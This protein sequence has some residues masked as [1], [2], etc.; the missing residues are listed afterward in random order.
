M[1]VSIVQTDIAWANPEANATAIGRML[2]THAG[3]DLY[4]LPEMF[5][6]GFATNPDDIAESDGLSIRW[7]SEQA[8]SRQCAMMGS[9]ATKEA[10]RFFNRLYFVWPDGNME[11]YDKRH[12]F[13]HGGEDKRFT[14]GRRR[15]VVAYRGFRILLQVCYDLRF[16]VFS[17]NRQDYDMA[18]YVA[19]WPTSRLSAWTALLRARAIENQC[20]VVGVNR[21]GQDPT[22]QYSGGSEIIDFQGRTIAGCQHGMPD[23]ATAHVSLDELAEA[24]RRFAVLPDADNFTL[25]D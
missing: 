4:V 13:S 15:V 3:A 20:F 2:D 18:V 19:N 9:V 17:R 16:P 22:C 10:G 7:M 24:R 11:H 12:L 8:R 23:V 6:T 25:A 1:K 14:A 5:S 21:V